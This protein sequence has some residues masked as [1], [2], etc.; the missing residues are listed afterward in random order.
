MKE[1]PNSSINSPVLSPT[2]ACAIQSL[3]I[4]SCTDSEYTISCT[5]SEYSTWNDNDHRESQNIG[6]LLSYLFLLMLLALPDH[7]LNIIFLQKTQKPFLQK[8]I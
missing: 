4:F 8:I 1:K 5:D 7:P 2:A 3:N 6:T